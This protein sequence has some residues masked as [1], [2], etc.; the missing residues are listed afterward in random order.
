MKTKVCFKCKRELPVE[1]FSKCKGQKDGLHSYCK[2]CVKEYHRS[3]R[4]GKPE[5]PKKL[6]LYALYK[7]DTLEC[8]GTC[9]QLA[10]WQGCDERTIRW[11]ATP[12]GSTRHDNGITVYPIDDDEEVTF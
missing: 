3:H 5:T 1:C 6:K 8:I 11:Y 4:P 9:K 12:W 7:G 10:E 2:E